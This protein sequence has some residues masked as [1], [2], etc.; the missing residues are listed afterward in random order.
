MFVGNIL[1]SMGQEAGKAYLQKLKGQNIA[2]ST[3]SNRQVL[4]MVIAGEYP[5]ALQTFNHHAYISK[6]AGA[7]VEWQPLEPLNATIH[8]VGLPKNAPH[9]Y[10]AMLFLDFVLSK[11]GQ[12]VYQSSDYLPAHPEILASQPDLKPGGGRFKRAT[13]IN[14]D[15]HYDKINEWGDFFE[16]QFV[17]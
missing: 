16:T 5:I 6:K 11:R 4:D 9:P 1:L 12:R 17:K 2:K 15:V 13:Y 14:P 10:T 7:P 3:A 8:T